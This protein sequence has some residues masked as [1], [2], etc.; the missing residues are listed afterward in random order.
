LLI[1]AVQKDNTNAI[2]Q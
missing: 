2:N 1:E